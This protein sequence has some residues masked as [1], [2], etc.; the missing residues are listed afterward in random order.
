MANTK[1]LRLA[2]GSIFQKGP[3]KIYFYRYQVDG[4]RKTV[5]LQT[6]NRA[7]AM[8]KA[9]EL[10]P[11]VKASTPEIVAA[12]VEYAKGFK[13]AERNLCV[14]DIWDYYS[15]HPDRAIPATI[16]EKLQYQATL[17]EFLDFL[18]APL[19][20]VRTITPQTAEEFSEYLKTTGIAVYTHNRKLKRIRK[21]FSVLSDFYTGSNPFRS[22]LFRR[23]R[24]EQNLGI[25]RQAFTRLQEQQILDVL[26]D[27]QHQVMNKP[28]IRVI[29]HIGMFTGQRLKDCVL[30][31]WSSIDMDRQRIW[32]KQFK[33]GKIVHNCTFNLLTFHNVSPES[34]QKLTRQCHDCHSPDSTFLV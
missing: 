20:M 2:V 11:I 22:T 16:H 9:Q 7:D 17:Q 18:N 23:E 31:K 34:H 24:E 6:S 30:L 28:E 1:S 33:T 21:I 8:K 26:E 12:H 32:V 3:G 19:R 4:R 10:I 25:R 14:S 27:E 15:R 5:S 29:Y 13:E